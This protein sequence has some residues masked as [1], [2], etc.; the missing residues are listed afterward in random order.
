MLFVCN[1]F[2]SL[3]LHSAPKHTAIFTNTLVL[4]THGPIAAQSVSGNDNNNNNNE[5]VTKNRRNKLYSKSAK[6]IWN[7]TH[8]KG[9]GD[10]RWKKSDGLTPSM[11]IIYTLYVSL[12]KSKYRPKRHSTETKHEMKWKKKS[13]R[14]KHRHLDI[15]YSERG[16][17]GATHSARRTIWCCLLN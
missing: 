12:S 2:Y 7:G 17:C 6:S 9:V 10:W 13:E 11:L 1:R 14:K 8:T 3:C 15:T 16:L 5:T 4:I